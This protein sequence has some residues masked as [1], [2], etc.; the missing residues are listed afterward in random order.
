MTCT[1]YFDKGRRMVSCPI[2]RVASE[3]DRLT[4]EGYVISSVQ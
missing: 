3:V 4:A 1:I 2:D